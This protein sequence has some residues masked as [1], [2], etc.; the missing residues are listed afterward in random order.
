[1]LFIL[2]IEGLSLLIFDARNHGLIR[3][4]HISPSLALAH[5]LFVDDVILMGTDTL[6]EWEAFDV[7]LETFCKASGMCISLEK[8]CFLYNNIDV[9]NLMDITR[10]LPY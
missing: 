3:G 1:M 2:L 5:L 4:I 6:Q 10:V 9:V 8:S 7:I